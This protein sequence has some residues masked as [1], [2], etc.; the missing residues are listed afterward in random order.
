MMY[1]A[2]STLCGSFSWPCSFRDVDGALEEQYATYLQLIVSDFYHGK[3]EN[4]LRS[5]Y[6]G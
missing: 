1:S 3:F 5:C 2:G 4:F 6:I